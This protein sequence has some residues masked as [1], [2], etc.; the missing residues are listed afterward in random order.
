[1]SCILDMSSNHS[2][3]CTWYLIR[4]CDTNQT[5]ASQGFGA[6]ALRQQTTRC[7][8]QCRK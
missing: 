5:S 8:L 3:P 4:T 1:M 7:E 6:K 2:N